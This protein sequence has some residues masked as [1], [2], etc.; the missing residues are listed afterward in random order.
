MSLGVQSVVEE[1]T[2]QEGVIFEGAP[3]GHDNTY[4]LVVDVACCKVLSEVPEDVTARLSSSAF[5]RRKMVCAC[6]FITELSSRGPYGR[7]KLEAIRQTGNW[8]DITW[9][10]TDAITPAGC[11]AGDCVLNLESSICARWQQS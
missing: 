4:E 5:Y 7:A 1:A 8:A 10:V 2:E 6:L 9:T 3:E 11:L